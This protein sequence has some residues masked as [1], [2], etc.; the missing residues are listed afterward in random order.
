MTQI[1]ESVS[2]AYQEKVGSGA[3]AG[4]LDLEVQHKFVPWVFRHFMYKKDFAQAITVTLTRKAQ[5]MAEVIIFQQPMLAGDLDLFLDVNVELQH[6]ESIR[7]YT[8]GANPPAVAP[9][10]H[11]VAIEWDERVKT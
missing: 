10:T 8:S 5:G 4:H 3:A 6:G 9:R 2:P 7:V 1:V 11:S